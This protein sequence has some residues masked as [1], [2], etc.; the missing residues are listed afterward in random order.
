VTSSSSQVAETLRA[1]ARA[2]PGISADEHAEQA[3]AKLGQGAGGR[4]REAPED[5][6]AAHQPVDL[7]AADLVP[8]PLGGEPQLVRR[9]SCT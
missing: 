4:R 5:P 8:R 7:V 2:N 6:D 1:V 9:F 3:L